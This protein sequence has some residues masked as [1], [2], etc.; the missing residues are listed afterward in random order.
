MVLNDSS[1]IIQF[2][3]QNIINELSEYIS[4]DFEP[5]IRDFVKVNG[6]FYSFEHRIKNHFHF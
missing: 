1:E 2:K 5:E 3:F 6:E 4:E